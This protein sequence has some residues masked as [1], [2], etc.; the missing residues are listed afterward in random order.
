MPL[1]TPAK[2]TDQLDLCVSDISS[3][4]NCT[5]SKLPN[6]YADSSLETSAP[7]QDI[8]KNPK[9]LKEHQRRGHL[10]F[11]AQWT[12]ERLC[13]THPARALGL[14]HTWAHPRHHRELSHT[15]VADIAELRDEEA[16]EALQELHN[17]HSFIHGKSG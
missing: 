7:S 17:C 4:C 3:A 12:V 2:D 1:I 14:L 10:P 11:S 16:L 9:P 13:N 6:D 8:P 5:A 15:T